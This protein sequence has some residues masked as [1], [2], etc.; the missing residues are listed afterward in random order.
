MSKF[1]QISI[2]SLL[3]VIAVFLAGNIYIQFQILNKL[4]PTFGELRNAKGEQRREL[5]LKQPV[6][7]A[8]IN[9]PIMVEVSEPLRVE[10]DNE[11]ITVEIY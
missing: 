8:N 9:E 6:I 11:P 10:I 4:P 2:V 3:L 7:R 5:I 1:T